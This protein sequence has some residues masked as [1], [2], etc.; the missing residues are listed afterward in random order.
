M[1]EWKEAL[2]GDVCHI[3]SSKRIFAK[4]YQTTGIPFYR[5]KEIIEKHNGSSVSTELYIS[6]ERFDELKTKF[7]VPRKGDILL[8]S[9]G[10]LGVPWLVDEEDFYFKDGNL[11]WLRTYDN[12]RSEFLYL[13]LNSPEAKHQIDAKCIGST[14]KALT[15]NTLNGFH[16]SLPDIETQ[17]KIIALAF[18][19]INKIKNNRRINKNL[20]EQ[21]IATVANMTETTSVVR[22]L[23]IICD[24][25][26]AGGT[27]SRKKSSYW[28]KP[29][30]AWFKNGEIKNNILISSEEY[31]SNEGLVNSSAKLIPANSILFAMYCVSTPQVAINAEECS[32]NQAVCTL[33]IS[34]YELMCYVYY[35]MIKYGINLTNLANGAAQ[36]NL[37]KKQISEFEIRMPSPEAIKKSGLSQ[38]IDLRKH[39]A[40]ENKTLTELRD[41]LLPKLI[42]GELNVSGL[43]L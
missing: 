31:I 4:E 6:Q 15:I 39:L 11:T 21:G 3:S 19:I 10:T 28:D 17:D 33:Q 26:C 1:S 20:I 22:P 5:G 8:T 34:D 24:N 2:L 37:N 43:G 35:Y 38:N 9:V 36:Q 25:I 18:A 29:E 23:S 40:S 7:D 16:I 42:S 32:C 14:Q 27:P 13:W 12:C 30:Y 41:S